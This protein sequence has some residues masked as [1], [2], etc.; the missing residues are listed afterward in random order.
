MQEHAAVVSFEF[1]GCSDSEETMLIVLSGM[2]RKR[3]SLDFDA[4]IEFFCF[5]GTKRSQKWK[6]V[7]AQFFFTP[8]AIF[9]G[10]SKKSFKVE[11]SRSWYIVVWHMF[12]FVLARLDERHKFQID[13]SIR[14]QVIKVRRSVIVAFLAFL[15][16]FGYS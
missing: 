15:V 7:V 2:S 12:G 8:K 6:K 14:G 10:G 13:I 4:Q 16:Y 5:L 9:L 1:E 3:C 11:R